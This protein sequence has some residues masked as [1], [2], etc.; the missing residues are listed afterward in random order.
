MGST[1]SEKILAKASNRQSVAPGDILYPN[2]ELVILHDGF[3]QTAFKQLDGLGY[4]RITNPERVMFVTDHQ[5]IY[6]NPKSIAQASANRTIAKKWQVGHFYDAGR[7]GHGHIFPMESGLVRPGMFL[8]AYDMHCTNFGAV[9]AF[10]QRAGPD[11][12]AVLATGTNWLIVPPTLKIELVGEYASGV[13]PRDLGFWLSS[14]LTSKEFDVEYDYRIIEFSGEVIRGMPLSYKVA[15]CNTLT[16]IG[17]ANVMFE[18][19]DQMLKEYPESVRSDT[20]ANYENILQIDIRQI[21]P[22]VSL[23]G[24]PDDAV[25]ISKVAGLKIDHAYIGACGSGMFDDFQLA[26][27]VLQKHRIAEHV[28][29]ILVPGTVSVAKQLAEKGLTNLF[30]DAGAMILPPGCGPCAGGVGG[31]I[32]P[33]EVSISTAAT[34][35]A[36][37]MGATDG[38][39]YLGSPLTVMASAIS[40]FI[41]DPRDRKKLK[42]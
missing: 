21:V 6:T 28:R 34:N 37:R 25:E 13:H 7:G 3:I 23:P 9:G 42:G 32:G 15:L 11:I 12:T 35:G 18:P 39:C 38:Y 17:V 19:T 10:A 24:S 41:Q 5:V 16:E 1:L 4:Q 20:N 31:P 22:Q 2:P 36:G 30:M 40:G 14:K 33:G 26:A 29:L 8:F 27:N